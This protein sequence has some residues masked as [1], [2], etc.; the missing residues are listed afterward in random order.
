MLVYSSARVGCATIYAPSVNESMLD[1][2]RCLLNG[3]DGAAAAKQ[4][5]GENAR[6]AGGGRA[7]EAVSRPGRVEEGGVMCCAVMERVAVVVASECRPD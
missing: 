2:P 7:E 1:N 6:L 3:A 5:S 4:L